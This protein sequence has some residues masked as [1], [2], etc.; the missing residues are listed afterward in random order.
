MDITSKFDLLVDTIHHTHQSFQQKAI[1]AVNINLTLRNWLI[2]YYI[3]EFEQKG[4]DRAQYG[5]QLV[6]SLSKKLGIKGL[7]ETNLKLS[8]QFYNIYPSILELLLQNSENWLPENIRQS[9]TDEL[10]I[11][12][13]ESIKIHQSATDELRGTQ[14]VAN[15]AELGHGYLLQIIQKTSFTHFV[16]LLKIEDDIKNKIL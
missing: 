8:R 3:V 14:N 11:T 2:G 12:I 7:A 4:E 9:T 1:K 13:S 15:I 5:E 6:P 10:Q 16:E